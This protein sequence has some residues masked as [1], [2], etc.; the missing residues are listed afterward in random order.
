MFSTGGLFKQVACPEG[1]KCSLPNC[2]FSHQVYK[3]E[4]KAGSGPLAGRSDLPGS[5]TGDESGPRKKRRIDQGSEPKDSNTSL[6]DGSPKIDL[7]APSKPRRLL[8]EVEEPAIKKKPKLDNALSK[9]QSAR[10]AVS[11]PDLR[12]SSVSEKKGSERIVEALEAPRSSS[13]SRQPVKA[14]TLA[15]KHRQE[16]LNP[17]LL[18][19]PPASHAFRLTVVQKIHEQLKRLNDG[20]RQEADSQALVLSDQELIITVL[21]EEEQAARENPSVYSSVMRLRMVAL[22]KMKLDEWKKQ[23]LEKVA[24]SSPAKESETPQSPIETGLTGEEELALLP[25]LVARQDGLEKFGYVLTPPG[26]AEIAAALT[27]VEAAH[28]WEQCDRCKSRFQVF[29]GRRKEDGALTTGGKCTYHHGRALRP[30]KSRADEMKAGPSDPI[31]TCCSQPLGASAGCTTAESHV[32]KVSEPK[33]LASILQFEPTPSNPNIPESKALCLDCEMGYTVYGLELIRLTATAWPSGDEVLDVL[34]RPMGEILDLNSRFSGVWPSHITE[35]VPYSDAVPLK[36]SQPTLP[37]PSVSDPGEIPSSAD[38][39][40]LPIVSSPAFAR[41]L[42]FAHLTPQTPLIGHALENDLIAARICHPT[43]ID[44]V[45]LFPHPRGLP[46]RY[47]LKALM[48]KYA[49]RDIQMAG[50]SGHDSKEDARAAGDLVRWKVREIWK[51]LKADGWSVRDGVFYPPRSRAEM[52]AE[53]AKRTKRK[54]S[55]SE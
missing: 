33:R 24:K 41:S 2:I 28:G 34:V 36:Q 31:Y 6:R 47:G 8:E 38:P 30:P 49:K 52:E 46:L 27:G 7:N 45:L 37:S 53:R 55:V 26:E 14:A 50:A 25:R 22:K 10:R 11:P 43:I 3:E 1:P 51:G 9:L 21:D 13:T 15:T 40:P 23:R 18:T 16:T 54:A 12:A 19:K 4:R 44:T 32:F 5:L 17:R 35:A 42:L 29:P 39:K 20:L 48:A